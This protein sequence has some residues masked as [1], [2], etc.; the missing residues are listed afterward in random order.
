MF[1]IHEENKKVDNGEMRT[2]NQQSGVRFFEF[3]M[4]QC[5]G[6]LHI[7]YKSATDTSNN[8]NYHASERKP[9]SEKIKFYM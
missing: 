8:R 3:Y 5:N 4:R 1:N 6:A 7:D 9:G 2:S